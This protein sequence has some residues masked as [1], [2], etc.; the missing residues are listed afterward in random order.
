MPQI[1]LKKVYGLE[2]QSNSYSQREGSLE[3]AKNIT[4]S[5]DNIYKKR[6]GFSTFYDPT[7]TTI[8]NLGEY[9]DKLIGFNS[10][11]VQ[12]YTQD[13]GG[14]FSSVLTLG[15][16]AVS[17]A[18]N[19][20]ARNVSANSN[21]YFKDDNGIKKLESATA[22]VLN[23]GIDGGTDLQVFLQTKSASE[24]FFRPNSQIAYRAVFGRKDANTNL[25]LGA[26]SQI[27]SATNAAVSTSA[28]WAY[29]GG[30]VTV[31]SSSHG[32]STSDVVYIYNASYTGGGSGINDAAYTVTVSSSSVFTF[33]ATVTTATA[34]GLSFGTY[35]TTELDIAVPPGCN[36]TEYLCQIY[37][38]SASV[39]S[40]TPADESTLQLVDEFNLSATQVSTGF[41]IYNDT[42]PDVLR[43]QYLYTN[44]N[45]GEAGGIA[46]SND[47]P[48]LAQDLALF[49]NFTFYSNVS[50]PYL[51]ELNLSTSNTT[52]FPTGSEFKIVGAVTRNYIGSTG[53]GN[54]TLR[55]T[56]ISVASPVVTITYAG[57]GF[58]TGDTVAIAEALDSSGVQMTTL[59]QGNYVISNALTNSFDITGTGS[60]VGL[61]TVSFAGIAKASGKRI[62][63]IDNTSSTSVAI[64]TTT[65]SIVR[66]LNR[67]PSGEVFAFY[68]SS[69]TDVPGK[70]ELES[71]SLT[72]TFTV[73][74]V[75]SAIVDSFTPSIPTSG[76]T[77][78]G[79]R[80]DGQSFLYISKFQQPEAVPA[81]QNIPVGSR[82]SAILRIAALRDSL[83][84]VKEDGVYRLNGTSISDFSVTLLDS[85][86]NCKGADTVAVLN[87]QVFLVSDQGTVAVSETAA[88][89]V[90]R[91]IE[92]LLVAIIGKSYF[93]TQSHAVGYQSERAYI[94]TTVTP[95][96]TTADTVYCYNAISDGWSTW[97]VPFLDAIVKS[98]DDKLYYIS[99]NNLIKQERKNQNRLDY[100]DAAYSALVLTTPSTTT[101]T[102]S[103]TTGVPAVGDVIVFNSVLN[104][105]T[106][107]SGTLL[108]F[109]LPYS[110]VVGN[111]GT[112]YQGITTDLITSPMVAGDSSV[113]KQFSEFQVGYRNAS[114]MTKAVIT[115]MNDTYDGS[116]ETTWL[117][118]I[119]T[120]GWGDLPWGSF[121]WGLEDG[122]NIVYES[123]SAQRI[124]LYVPLDVSRGTFIQARIVHTSAAEAMMIQSLAYTARAYGQRVTR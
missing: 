10:N 73:S 116:A 51:L 80:V 123:G 41:I 52:T 29:S 46:A 90:S 42:T 12:V 32:L 1:E 103:V 68:V 98:T 36:S 14:D 49:K 60:I 109:A 26:P 38:T 112:L 88:R 113:W 84:I 100:S 62:F 96:A 65:R 106:A 67:D 89:I 27:A 31:T 34:G 108:T 43:G 25:V 78:T 70:M 72:Q 87:N 64:D 16:V 76:S 2:I 111:V 47:K 6:R 40:L 107:V 69:V 119:Q 21:L 101:A 97:D 115:F 9:A 48:P 39:T 122:T 33:T 114:S 28:T 58:A 4:L 63:Y 17:I 19:T 75:S 74:A 105:I 56:S 92:P 82:S 5:Q 110:F 53:A 66:A 44:P 61:T 8:R 124:R 117:S 3:R 121:P 18:A 30:T 94:C 102:F 55:A 35:K 120:G 45:T 7:T 50:T 79:T 54:R 83:I 95:Q 13:S 85:T 81:G 86:V 20:K 57:H 23:A 59:A 104:R 93:P 118:Q 91:P 22:N 24:S 11:S 37:R 77:I 71:R 99:A 15:G